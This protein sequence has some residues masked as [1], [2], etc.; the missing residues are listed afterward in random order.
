MLPDADRSC[1]VQIFGLVCYGW[2][3]SLSEAPLCCIAWINDEGGKRRRERE[4]ADCSGGGRRRQQRRDG[5]ENKGRESQ[6]RQRFSDGRADQPLWSWLIWSAWSVQP[7]QP[8]I[9][10]PAGPVRPCWGVSGVDAAQRKAKE[11]Q[12]PY[13]RWKSVLSPFK[14]CDCSK[15]TRTDTCIPYFFFTVIL[16]WSEKEDDLSHEVWSG[17]SGYWVQT[18]KNGPFTD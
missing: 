4:R 10:H 6:M 11:P 5:P 13:Y 18:K 2:S 14:S 3:V 17:T 7:N 12:E 1:W 8:V 16:V 15:F 9:K